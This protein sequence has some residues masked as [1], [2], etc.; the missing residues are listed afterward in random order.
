VVTVADPV[1]PLAAVVLYP[2][3]IDA[4]GAVVLV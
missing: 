1:T 2:V 3:H 4:P